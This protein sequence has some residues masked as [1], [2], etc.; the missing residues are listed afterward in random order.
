MRSGRGVIVSAATGEGV[1]DLLALID[2]ALA[3]DAADVIVR[4]PC[5]EGEAIAWLHRIGFSV[6]SDQDGDDMIM[7]VLAPK[8]EVDRFMKRWTGVAVVQ[9]AD[10]RAIA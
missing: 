8:E 1:D 4:V 6:E 7:R 9:A 5:A 3:R 10:A 2:R